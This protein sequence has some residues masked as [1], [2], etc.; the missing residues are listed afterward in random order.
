LKDISVTQRGWTLDVLNIVRRLVESRRRGDESGFGTGK[1]ASLLTTAPTGEF[2]T[3]DAY[4]FTRELEQ[5]HPDNRHVKDNPVKDFV[6]R[7][8][9]PPAIAGATRP[10]FT[11]ARR[12]RHL[13]SAVTPVSIRIITLK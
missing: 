8:R 3:T 12:A 11:V 7:G 9:N 5:L 6:S 1:G 13:A 10:R 4:T 2:T